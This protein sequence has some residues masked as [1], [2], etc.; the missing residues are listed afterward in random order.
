M[1]TLRSVSRDDLQRATD[2]LTI[3]ESALGSVAASHEL[4][5]EMVSAHSVVRHA[6]RES[7]AALALPPRDDLAEAWEAAEAALPA[8]WII[9]GLYHQTRIDQWKAKAHLVGSPTH[10]FGHNPATNE[11]G[12]GATKEEALLDLARRLRARAS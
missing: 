2:A 6:L 10:P 1:M 5:A 8:G 3:A 11:Q 9:V 4:W 12:I 7:R